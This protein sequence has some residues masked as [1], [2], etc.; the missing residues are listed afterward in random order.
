M[1]SELWAPAKTNLLRAGT[2]IVVRASSGLL[3][4]GFNLSYHNTET[5]LSTIDPHNGNLN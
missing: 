1:A 4:G 3:L 5:M 2:F